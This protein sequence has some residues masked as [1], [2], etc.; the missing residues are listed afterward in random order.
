MNEVNV[1]KLTTRIL[2]NL[3]IQDVMYAEIAEPGAMGNN[4]GII[5]YAMKNKRLFRYETTIFENETI[6]T[7]ARNSLLR[8][9]NG[10]KIE[11]IAT[12]ST[13]F[14][15]Y[16]GGMGN[17]I[18]VNKNIYLQKL[19]NHFRFQ[20]DGNEY[21]IFCSVPGVFNFL[22]HTLNDLKN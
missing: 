10:L 3:A 15:Y 17:H 4:G 9:Q 20:M 13:I 14:D 16:Y 7:Q 11:G 22:V 2:N 6:Y 1:I 8:H 5:V 19:R 18:L 21:T 12:V